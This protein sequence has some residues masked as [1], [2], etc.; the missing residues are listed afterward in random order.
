M[1]ESL[2]RIVEFIRKEKSLDLSPVVRQ[3]LV[4]RVS[5]EPTEREIQ[6]ARD[7]LAGR[8]D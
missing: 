8:S 3:A 1:H 7:Q 4:N 5:F 6:R 2:A